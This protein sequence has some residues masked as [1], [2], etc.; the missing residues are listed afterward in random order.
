M[1]GGGTKASSR[2]DWIEVYGKPVEED[3]GYQED[4]A[5][6]LNTKQITR[7]G[8]FKVRFLLGT[9][10][11]IGLL[12]STCTSNKEDADM[13]LFNGKI[14]T[15]D[16]K[17]STAEAVAIKNGKILAVGEDEDLLRL[18]GEATETVDL[19]GHTLIPGLIEGHAH[20]ISASQS[21]FFEEIP[22]LHTIEQ[23]LQ[24]IKDEAQEKADGEWIIHPKCFITRF[25]EMRQVTKAE[26]DSVAPDNPVFLNG[27]Y[28]G[29]V[30]SKALEMSKML[31]S[32]E[33][34]ILRDK[35]TGRATGVIRRSA[36]KLLS[37]NDDKS[38]SH[39]QKVEALRTLFR[40]YNQIGITSVTSGGGPPGELAM[41]RELRKKGA[42]TVRVFHNIRI[43][44]DPKKSRDELGD[45]VRGL[46][47]KTGDGN[48]WV[49][50]GALKV[51]IDGGV[52]TGT[53]FLR[54]G[55][56]EKAKDIYGITDPG[57]RGELLLSKA[58]LV[59]L[60]TVAAEIGWKFTAHVTGGGGVDTLIAAYED[61]NR[62][63]PIKKKRF[64]IIHGNF[65]TTDAIRKMSALGILADMQPAWF[66]K[67]TNL[68]TY[69]LGEETIDTF[70][71]YNSLMKEGVIINGGSD[72]MVKLDANTSINPYNPFLAMW[73]V[74]TRKTESGAVFNPEE[75]ISRE[76]ALR[77]YTIN[78]AYASFEEDIKGSIEVGKLADLVLLSEDILTCSEENIKEIKPLLTVVDGR[79][80][81]RNNRF[82]AVGN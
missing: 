41:F 14:V 50:V 70:H 18:A 27:S 48:E 11:V 71:P 59:R 77:M 32:K 56:G 42:L 72:H 68:L 45:I 7:M 53:A 81:Y 17:F 2:L 74:I 8:N 37:I 63:N 40:R 24:W 80:V 62:L 20:P 44:L 66:Y 33:E 60:I 65:F 6:A 30:N 15:V 4:L 38:I 46:G 35:R 76:Q 36:F 25:R 1:M 16:K 12:T 21:E 78:N 31:Q 3:K 51:S 29:V 28:G 57:Y 13:I 64:S 61:V 47:Y 54:D 55:W 69:V 23:L 34:G 39:E 67:D 73:S 26:L 52:L 79:I 58:D 5:S 9:S 49:R 82:L 75:A 43:L 19:K 10:F 22:D